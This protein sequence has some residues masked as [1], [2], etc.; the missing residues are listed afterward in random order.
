MR[1]K[2]TKLTPTQKKALGLFLMGWPIYRIAKQLD[3]TPETFN[4]W[5]R[6]SQPF[7]RALE[8]AVKGVE[9]AVGMDMRALLKSSVHLVSEL[10]E[11]PSANIKLSAAK[12]AFDMN[13]SFVAR[14]E[15]RELLL[16]LE[17]RA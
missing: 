9:D 4:R 14:A 3:I 6:T 13:Q 15:E 10:V 16:N 17:P 11:H 8:E 2:S 1:P 12:L 7:K 5:Q